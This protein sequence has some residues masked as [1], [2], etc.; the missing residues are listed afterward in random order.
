MT[1]NAIPVYPSEA[2]GGYLSYNNELAKTANYTVLSKQRGTL[3]TTLG[4]VAA[5]TFTLP[6]LSPLLAFGF[7]NLADQNMIV[8]SLAGD[9]MVAMN[10]LSADSVA[11]Q[12]GGQLIGGHVF[13]WC[14]QAGTKWYVWN[15][16]P[17]ANTI[18]V[19][20]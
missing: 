6:A 18:T 13:V 9:D 11:F 14:N 1:V 10:D 20:T 16:S 7:L 17:G 8:A 4:A 3:F 5:V 15:R 19:A 2:F 12:T